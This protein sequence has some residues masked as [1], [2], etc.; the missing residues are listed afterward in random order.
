MERPRPAELL[1]RP[2]LRFSRSAWRVTEGGH[3]QAEAPAAAGRACASDGGGAR[4]IAI[5]FSQDIAHRPRVDDIANK[6]VA[7]VSAPFQVVGRPSCPG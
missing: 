6:A 5:S 1:S 3:R 2:A 4:F 7:G